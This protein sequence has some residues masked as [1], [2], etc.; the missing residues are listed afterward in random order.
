MKLK[1][2][3]KIIVITGKD[4]GKESIVEVVYNE[5]NKVLAKDINIATKHVKPSKNDKG[6]IIKVARP[7]NASNVMFLDPKENKP[8]RIGYKIVDG[9][10][11]RFSK[12]SGEII[13]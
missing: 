7:I 12:K 2:G 9:K 6:G 4:K 11:V 1:K 8:S 10:K 13:N 3:D 5:K